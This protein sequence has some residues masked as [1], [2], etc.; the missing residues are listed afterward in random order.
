MQV[1]GQVVAEGGKRGA[2]IPVAVL[3]SETCKNQDATFGVRLR[4]T[5]LETPKPL[6]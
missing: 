6:N 4:D 3:H 5:Y 1:L 2:A